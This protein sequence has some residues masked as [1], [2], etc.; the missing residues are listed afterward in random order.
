M[1]KL[2]WFKFTPSDWMMGKIQRCEEVTQARF[3]RLC[4]LY[5]NKNCLMSIEDAIIEID[6]LHFEVL[7]AKKIV[8]L[9][10]V[11][12]NISFLDEQ[13]FEIKDNFD[14]K[15]KNGII[16]NLKRWHPL[17]HKQFIDKKINLE[18]AI[19]QS[20]FI[21]NLSLPDNL[22]I[23]TQSQNIA[24]KTRLDKIRE[25]NINPDLKIDWV[26]LLEQFNEITGKESRVINTKTKNAFLLR[27]KEGYSKQNIL[28][29]IEN[30]F[31]DSYHKETNHKYLT[32][33]FISRADKLE[34]YSTI[35][36]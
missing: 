3:V 20:K 8:S 9:N 19:N 36:S 30:C 16:G 26:K 28:D 6:K 34:K 13:F 4:C 17:I 12:F 29:A 5:W 35:K 7:E 10:D 11:Y 22:P 15:S 33:E 31:N 24:E 23:A 18:E 2:Q 14:D 27:L 1:D 21:A 32:L 25:E